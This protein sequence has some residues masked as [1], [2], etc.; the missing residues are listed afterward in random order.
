MF[1]DHKVFAPSFQVSVF[2]V[3]VVTPIFCITVSD[4]SSLQSM[5]D[6]FISSPLTERVEVVSTY[7]RR[8]K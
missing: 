7:T 8:L 3:G 1:V 5:V 4:T 2:H 6:G